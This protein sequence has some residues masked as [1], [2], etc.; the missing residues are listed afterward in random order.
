[1]VERENP[2]NF[3]ISDMIL[4]IAG[5]AGRVYAYNSFPRVKSTIDHLFS[6][7]QDAHTSLGAAERGQGCGHEELKKFIKSTKTVG[8]FVVSD[9]PL[10]AGPSDSAVQCTCPPWNHL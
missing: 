4:P 6:L 9:N 3:G 5:L 2:S 1:M 8:D 7:A 10:F